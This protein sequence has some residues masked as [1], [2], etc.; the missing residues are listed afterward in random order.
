MANGVSMR[1][2][3]PISIYS[4]LNDFF[5]WYNSVYWGLRATSL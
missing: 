3:H 5:T 1:L 2:I 4:R